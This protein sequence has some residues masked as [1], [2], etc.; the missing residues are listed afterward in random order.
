MKSIYIQYALNVIGTII[1]IGLIMNIRF[2]FRCYQLVLFR[3]FLNRESLNQQ[4]KRIFSGNQVKQPA[5]QKRVEVIC[6]QNEQI[7]FRSD[8]WLTMNWCVIARELELNQT[9]EYLSHSYFMFVI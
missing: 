6:Q 5:K 8:S 7:D 3:C 9:Q 2:S 1:A 4:N